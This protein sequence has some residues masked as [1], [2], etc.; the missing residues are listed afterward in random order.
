[1]DIDSIKKRGEE[2][3]RTVKNIDQ[4]KVKVAA[5]TFGQLNTEFFQ[6]LKAP[7]QEA[8][9][10]GRKKY[11]F[12]TLTLEGPR[13]ATPLEGFNLYNA[14]GF[15]WGALEV[16]LSLLFLNFIL[17]PLSLAAGY[18]TSM[19]FWWI[20]NKQNK[21]KLHYLGI[22]MIL[23]HTCWIVLQIFATLIFIVLP[24]LFGIKLFFT[25]NLLKYAFQLETTS[26]N[27]DYQSLD[28][29]AGKEGAEAEI[30]D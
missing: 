21:R 8:E 19:L 1:M 26:V 11:F 15:W 14:L 2:T 18:L 9:K 16:A 5:K 17:G 29:E 3:I 25:I 24:I 7:L 28:E 6:Q 12:Q 23:M 22:T 27:E 20:F 10:V 30:A 4:E 13:V